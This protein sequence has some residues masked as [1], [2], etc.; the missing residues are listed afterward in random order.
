MSRAGVLFLSLVAACLACAS[1]VDDHGWYVDGVRV[2]D[3]SWRGHDGP[4]LA[5]LI[6]TD[7]PKSVYDFWNT[8]PGNVPVPSITS[9]AP[10]T[11]VEAVV[12]FVG[13]EPDPQG[14]CGVWGTATVISPNGSLLADRVEVPLWVGRPPPPGR[15][16]GISEHG[17]GMS[18]ESLPGSYVFH[19]V[20]T[21]RVANRQVPLEQEL[22]IV[23]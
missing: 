7:D 4:F 23:Q 16:L 12:F 1:T 22:T 2:A 15:A 20:V 21:D 5:T 13:C 18:N 10:D 3:E 9:I 17:I 14:N 11:S 8:K 19:M 6:L